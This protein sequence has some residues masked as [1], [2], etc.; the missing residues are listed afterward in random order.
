MNLNIVLIDIL[1]VNGNLHTYRFIPNN[2]YNRVVIDRLRDI[3]MDVKGNS[4]KDIGSTRVYHADE[5]EVNKTMCALKDFNNDFKAYNFTFSFEHMN[6]PLGSTNDGS[7]GIYNFVLP[8]AWRLTELY[9]VDPFD[10]RNDDF[11][12]KKQ[13]TYKILWDDDKKIQLVEMNLRSRRGSFS[14]K[15]YGTAEMIYKSTNRF[16]EAEEISDGVYLEDSL[17][18]FDKKVKNSFFEDLKNSL[19]VEPNFNGIGFDLKKFFQRKNR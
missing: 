1:E 2:R 3:H 10:T 7:G 13:F 14:F 11:K 6:I 19:I 5:C 9:V 12:R 18:Y 8:S 15:I 16:V 17:T 4:D